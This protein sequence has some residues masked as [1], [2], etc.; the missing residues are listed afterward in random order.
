MHSALSSASSLLDLEY[1]VRIWSRRNARCS[2]ARTVGVDPT[3][4]FCAD[5]V[6]EI[7]TLSSVSVKRGTVANVQ[8]C[9]DQAA[10][11]TAEIAGNRP[12]YS[13]EQRVVAVSHSSVPQSDTIRRYT[14]RP[15]YHAS[16]HGLNVARKST[17]ATCLQMYSKEWQ[18]FV[19][20]MS[21]TSI[22]G[23]VAAGPLFR[24]GGQ[25]GGSGPSNSAVAEET[26]RHK[27]A[28]SIL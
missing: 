3:Q 24:S 17:V 11:I 8:K 26:Q 21:K 25:S 2:L 19:I 10:S 18:M 5:I 28:K 23:D 16:R 1:T 27:Q 14:T 20:F 22:L 7:C 9:I 15:C 6:K 12:L 13:I 4:V